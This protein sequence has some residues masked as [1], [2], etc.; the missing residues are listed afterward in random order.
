[1]SELP[2]G[3]TIARV[4]DMV[5]MSPK[6]G[7]SDD[8][9]AGFVPLQRLGTKFRSRH[10]HE[11]KK[12][13]EIKKG[14]THFANGDVLLARI[15]PSFENGKAGI[16]RDLPNGVGAGSTEY[17]VFRPKPGV[18]LA[19]YLLA[20]F[21]TTDFL[22]NGEQVMSGA[23]GQQRVPRQYVLDA[24]IP[25]APLSEQK[26]I[27][28]KLDRL[29]AAVDTCKA[30]L[31]AIPAVLKRF[32][33]S[34]LAAATSGELTEEWRAQNPTLVDSQPLN[35]KVTDAHTCAGGHKVGNAAAPTEGVHD[36]SQDVLPSGWS[37]LELRDLVEPGKPI[38]YG[39]LKPGPEL[40]N[41]VPYVRVADF[42][43]ERLN[44]ETI[45]NTSAKIDAEFKRSRLSTGDLLI[46][47][48]G[49]VGRVVVIPDA[50]KG[51]NI[52]QDSARLSIQSIVNR[53]YVLFY[54][55]SEAV[56]RRMRKATKGVAVRGINIGDLRALQI[57]LPSLDE[58]GEIVRRVTLL[59]SYA[60]SLDRALREARSRCESVTAAILKKAFSGGLV[61][62]N[63]TDVPPVVPVVGQQRIHSDESRKQQHPRIPRM[64]AKRQPK[65][66]IIPVIDA[67]R[68]ASRPLTTELLL[69][70]AG[71]PQDVS[72]DLV[73][74]FFLD[75]R[76]CVS[77]KPPRIVRKREGD[78]DV[79]SLWIEQAGP[80]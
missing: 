64:K 9:D 79:F 32:R 60:D 14:Y 51:A 49:T 65:T 48:R 50:L 46:S 69:I 26:R 72:A 4:G 52:T 37:L 45:R 3:W 57:A 23:V 55:R 2:Q 21:K 62:Q 7:C 40:E 6:N 56:Q 67:L 24:K 74:R 36:L 29:L 20:Y 12:W 39:I 77:A 18:V 76:E 38:T 41:G 13:R 8:T 27:A 1:V 70:A 16:V 54:L 25:L 31:D 63:P 30:R 17:F 58:Q 80:P 53:D 33:Q 78:Q 43:G 10:S 34:V 73:E 5:D 15:T 75:V 35:M 59:F 42:P 66:Q 19:E 61:P 22:R 71:Y 28:D 68:A 44:L 11:V 47:I